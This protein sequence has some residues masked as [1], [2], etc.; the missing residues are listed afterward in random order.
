MPEMMKQ[1]QKTEVEHSQLEVSSS[2]WD[3]ASMNGHHESRTTR[4]KVKVEE[5][6][7]VQVGA[8]ARWLTVDLGYHTLNIFELLLR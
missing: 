1:T 2:G 5:R 4:R 8:W 3:S 6:E 7:E